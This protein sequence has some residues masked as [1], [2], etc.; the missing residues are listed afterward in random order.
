[1]S[2]SNSFKSR[3]LHKE[4]EEAELDSDVCQKKNRLIIRSE[5]EEC[6]EDRFE[7]GSQN[8]FNKSIDKNEEG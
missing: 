5:E 1:M 6:M 4:Q 7:L 2:L 3:S 8:D